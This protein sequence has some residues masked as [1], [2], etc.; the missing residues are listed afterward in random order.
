V[1][2]ERSRKGG[3]RGKVEMKKWRGQLGGGYEK[4]GDQKKWICPP[5]TDSVTALTQSE[6]FTFVLSLP[7][8]SQ[9]KKE[10]KKKKNPLPFTLALS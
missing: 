7:F 5:Q 6:H 8:P 10:K 1:G 4:S 2:E 9:K 3:G